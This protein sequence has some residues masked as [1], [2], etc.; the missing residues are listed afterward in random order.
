MGF[1][2]V[3][4]RAC[5]TGLV[6]RIMRG[7]VHGRS[8]GEERLGVYSAEILRGHWW[9]ASASRLVTNYL[10]ESPA[11]WVR[12]NALRRPTRTSWLVHT[13]AFEVTGSEGGIGSPSRLSPA[14]LSVKPKAGGSWVGYPQAA[15]L[16]RFT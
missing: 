1:R 4:I 9:R 6:V 11:S 3:L 16:P 14:L 8:L 13:R 2:S 5:G 10:F 7:R 12:G 15:S